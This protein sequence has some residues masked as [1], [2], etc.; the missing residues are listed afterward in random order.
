[1]NPAVGVMMKEMIMT[2]KELFEWLNTCP[3]HRGDGSETRS[4]WYTIT[5][6]YGLVIVC[7]KPDEIEEEE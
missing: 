6:D 5:D 3:M 4:N 2:R 1:M 7:F